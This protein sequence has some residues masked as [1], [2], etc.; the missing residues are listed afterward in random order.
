[1][2][3]EVPTWLLLDP[4]SIM[5]PQFPLSLINRQGANTFFGPG[6]LVSVV[7]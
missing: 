4:R 7:S 2:S 3:G 5:G 1:M 6:E